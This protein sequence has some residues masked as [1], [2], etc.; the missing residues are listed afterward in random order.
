MVGEERQEGEA[1][2]PPGWHDG[3]PA[4]WYLDPDQAPLRRYWD[5]SDWTEWTDATHDDP[6]DGEHPEN[7]TLVAI[8]WV[9]AILLPLVGLIIGVVLGSRGDRRG[10]QIVSAALVVIFVVA[11]VATVAATR[12][13]A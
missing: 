8:G 1:P 7:D 13:G 5:G 9:T 10:A 2:P 6:D 12:N 4:G 11:L 3:A